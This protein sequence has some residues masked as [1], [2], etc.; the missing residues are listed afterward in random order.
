MRV[1]RISN[2]TANNTFTL[3]EETFNDD[4]KRIFTLKGHRFDEF[5]EYDG[6]FMTSRPISTH[7]IGIVDSLEVAETLMKQWG[8]LAK[9]WDWNVFGYTIKEHWLNQVINPKND[10]YFTSITERTYD[11]DCTLNCINKCD[12]ACISKFD[13]RDTPVNVNPGEFAW[14][15]CEDKISLVL[16]V[17][18][19][20]TKDE[21]KK[22]FKPGVYGD[23]FDDCYTV[24]DENEGGHWHPFSCHIFPYDGPEIPNEIKNKF[25][26]SAKEYLNDESYQELFA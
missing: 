11:K 18:S 22:H 14:Y 4:V 6:S 15:L 12:S 9:K 17:D 16:V 13:G 2:M 1:A 20:Y 7:D 25:L 10:E 5:D 24:V 21:W 8:E 19:P 23:W 3:D 26:K